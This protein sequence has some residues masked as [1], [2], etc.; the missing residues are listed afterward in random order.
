MNEACAAMG[1]TSLA[2]IRRFVDANYLNYETYRREL[3]MV[4]GVSVLGC[5]TEEQH[6]YHYVVVEL[7]EELIG[8][9]RD[10]VVD[11]L[12]AE[13]VLA[14]RY[15]WP[16]CHRM[17]PYRTLWPDVGRHLP[18]TE[19]IAERVLI[20]P[21]GVSVSIEDVKNI[22]AILRS[23][24]QNG[25]EIVRRLNHQAA[26]IPIDGGAKPVLSPDYLS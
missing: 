21:T 12:H 19:R 6:N 20:L 2:N 11:I 23:A 17:E 22:C 4:P 15:F 13:N 8:I 9:S 7:D 1:L 18:H 25:K 5:D 14:R 3:D 24:L 10:Q 26:P 16:G